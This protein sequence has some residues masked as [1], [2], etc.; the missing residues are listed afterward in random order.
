MK[1]YQIFG[2]TIPRTLFAWGAMVALTLLSITAAGQSHHGSSRLVM[3][4]SVAL[5]AWYKSRLLVRNYM[6]SHLAGPVFDW[7]V[8]G[9]ALVAPAA[10]VVSAL[11]EAG[12]L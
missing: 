5:I 9:F 7:V 4:I 3:T 1:T 8:R 6:E 10:L 12:L 11:R 2:F